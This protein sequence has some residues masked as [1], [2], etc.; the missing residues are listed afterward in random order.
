MARKRKRYQVCP[1]CD[2]FVEI[3]CPRCKGGKLI[4]GGIPC[5]KCNASGKIICQ[6]CQGEGEIPLEEPQEEAQEV[7]SQSVR[8][9]RKKRYYNRRSYGYR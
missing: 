5:P 9:P 7:S 8:E 4:K 3:V 2:G 6:T 1:N